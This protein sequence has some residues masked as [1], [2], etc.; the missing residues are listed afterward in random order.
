LCD[1]R[2]GEE[3]GEYRT[4]K[5]APPGHLKPPAT[6]ESAN[7]APPLQTVAVIEGKSGAA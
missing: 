6:A 2:R 1:A 7:D 5:D 4:E 3:N